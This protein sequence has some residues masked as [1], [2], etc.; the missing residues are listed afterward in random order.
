MKTDI[1]SGDFLRLK[2]NMDITKPLHRFVTVVGVRGQGDIWARLTYE[3][4]PTFCYECGM[5]GHS[6]IKCE[7]APA[8]ENGGNCT[9]QYGDWLRASPLINQSQSTLE[10]RRNG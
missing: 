6:D 9:K 2:V 3:C 1:K 4:L 10:F 7:K 5:I 8:E